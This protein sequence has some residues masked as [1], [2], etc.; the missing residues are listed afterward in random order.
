MGTLTQPMKDT[1]PFGLKRE[2]VGDLFKGWL[3]KSWGPP[4]PKKK[5][6][7]PNTPW[8]FFMKLLKVWLRWRNKAHNLDLTDIQHI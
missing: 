2:V 4:P 1:P 7:K 5:K 8:N 6:K 3:I